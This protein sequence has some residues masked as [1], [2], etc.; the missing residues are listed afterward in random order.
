MWLLF[1]WMLADKLR[2]LE[3]SASAQG[4]DPPWPGFLSTAD[5]I[6]VS[7]MLDS[8]WSRHPNNRLSAVNSRLLAHGSWLRS[9]HF[10]FQ[11]SVDQE[12]WEYAVALVWRT[13]QTLSG[14]LLNHHR[15]SLSS[16]CQGSS[17]KRALDHLT[18]YSSS[19]QD[20]ASADGR[21]WQGMSAQLCL[22][23]FYNGWAVYHKGST[24][25]VS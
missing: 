24:Q 20:P 1:L 25:E 16:W 6:S 11:T 18:V 5:L 23:F 12:P 14:S 3:K 9:T 10:P 22:L 19:R 2:F 21:S 17:Y 8:L 4:I 13:G 15:L 7:Y